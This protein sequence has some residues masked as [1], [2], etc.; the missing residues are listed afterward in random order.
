M[1][2]EGVCAWLADGIALQVV[3]LAA[4]RPAFGAGTVANG[5][6]LAAVPAGTAASMFL[7]ITGRH[8]VLTIGTGH[9]QHRWHHLVSAAG[10]EQDE[11]PATADIPHCSP[12]K[13]LALLTFT[14]LYQS[15]L[16]CTEYCKA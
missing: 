8:V 13:S 10:T 16:L 1:L 7:L 6:E 11:D 5:Q 4:C 15:C 12:L 14:A 3:F 9:K 2:S